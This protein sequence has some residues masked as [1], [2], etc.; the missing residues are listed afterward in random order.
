MTFKV[1]GSPVAQGRPRFFVR[2]TKGGGIFTGAFDPK[3]S[4]SW[5]ETIKWQAIEAM[6]AENFSLLEGPLS[7]TL[8]FFLPR[9]KS[10]SKKVQCHIKRP[11]VDN[12]CKAVK[13]ALRSICYHDDSQIISSVI[14]KAYG[15]QPGVMISIINANG[16]GVQNV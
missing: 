12:L 14:T 11:D 4:K 15:E 9:P 6:K 10:L 7:M 2:K 16:K 13:D 8:H 3:T 5:K 1:F